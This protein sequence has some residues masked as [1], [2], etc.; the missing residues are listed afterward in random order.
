MTSLRLM[1]YGNHGTE[2]ERKG[3]RGRERCMV[4][5]R[6][7]LTRLKRGGPQRLFTKLYN[8]AERWFEGCIEID[9]DQEDPGQV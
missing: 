4:L 8:Q 2:R 3:T 6:N 9:R 5:V 1:A 7:G